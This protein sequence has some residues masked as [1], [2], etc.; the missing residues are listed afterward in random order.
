MSQAMSWDDAVA[1]LTAPGGIFALTQAEVRGQQLTVFERAPA[2]LRAVFGAARS[3]ADLPFLV[4]EDECLSFG[5]TSAR[6]AEIGA[7]LVE[8]FG[9]QPGDRV[10]IAMRNYPEWI[11]GF[12]ASRRSR[13]RRLT[14]RLWT[15][16]DGCLIGLETRRSKL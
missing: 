8:R 6:I 5:E 2:S 7:L 15:S 1:R 16:D 10:A 14:Q 9:V 4:Y 3:R 11:L 12:A 13:H